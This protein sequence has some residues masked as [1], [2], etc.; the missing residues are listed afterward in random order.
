MP[1]GPVLSIP[2]LPPGVVI[3]PHCSVAWSP[4]M[5]AA[6]VGEAQVNMAMTA[7]PPKRNLERKCCITSILVVDGK[8]AGIL[9]SL[10][11]KM[12]EMNR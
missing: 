8:F 12:G 4:K 2:K 5:V 3:A 9:L 10:M 7:E 6:L 11:P 1:E